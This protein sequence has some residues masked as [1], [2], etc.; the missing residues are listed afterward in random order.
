[1]SIADAI[2]NLILRGKQ[3]P[4]QTALITASV[5]ASTYLAFSYFSPSS[6]SSLAPAMDES[7]T[8][9]IMNAILKK[10]KLLVPKLLS[11]AQ[12]IKAQVDQAGQ[13]MDEVT[14]MKNYI[15]PHYL[16]N[17]QE[18]QD[19][20]LQEYDGDEDE[21]EEAVN[22]YCEAGDEELINIRKVI[23]AQ[24]IQF[25]GDSDLDSVVSAP[26]EGSKAAN[27]SVADVVNLLRELAQQ[28]VQFSDDFCG[29]FVDEYGVPAD[30]EGLQE[31]Q[32]GLMVV[33][34]K[35]VHQ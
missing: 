20:V 13:D 8:K 23:R 18:I 31:F 19:M 2:Q 11:A 35:Y 32:A 3:S 26:A 33:S 25:G 24:H 28:M 9:E 7:E 22:Y 27:M 30:Q 12:N 17:L 15:L 14:L 1:M 10:L 5:L 29:N 16:T 21:L 4:A 34:Q 6:N